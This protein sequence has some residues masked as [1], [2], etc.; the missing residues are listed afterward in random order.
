[1]SRTQLVEPVDLWSDCVVD[2]V[3]RL[4]ARADCDLSHVF[5]EDRLKPVIAGAKDRKKRGTVGESM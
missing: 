2:N 1:M 5:H 4:V 3:P